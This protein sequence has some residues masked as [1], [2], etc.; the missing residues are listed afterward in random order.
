LDIEPRAIHER[1]PLIIG[2]R[3]EVEEF[4]RVQKESAVGVEA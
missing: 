1:T 4:Q 3:T 2:S